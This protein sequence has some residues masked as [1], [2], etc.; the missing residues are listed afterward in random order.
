[1][2]LFIGIAVVSVKSSEFIK[3]EIGNVFKAAVIFTCI[4]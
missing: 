3:G 1:M 4:L 2:K